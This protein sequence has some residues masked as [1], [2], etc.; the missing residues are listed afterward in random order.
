MKQRGL[1]LIELMMALAMGS[2]LIAGAVT[3]YVRSSA[4]YAVNETVARL[5]ETAR[6]AVS[7]LEPHIRLAGHWGLGGGAVHMKGTTGNAPLALS[8]AASRCGTE[9][10]LDLRRAAG[11]YNNGY[12][13]PC[14]AAGGGAVTGSDVLV[15]R[16]GEPVTAPPSSERLQLYTTRSGTGNR[17]FLSATAPGVTTDAE[18][19]DLSAHAYYLARNS[20]GQAG[21]PALRRKVLQ[22]GPGIGDEEIMPG[23]EDFQVRFGIDPGVDDD[24]DGNPDHHT[25]I[26]ARYVDPGDTALDSALIVA[27]RIWLRVRSE[28]P[29]RGHVD[30]RTYRYADVTFHPVGDDAGYRRLLV[31][32]TIQLRNAAGIP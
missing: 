26:A 10:P 5:H 18:I 21:L 22:G 7:T 9:F 20:T 28:Q 31:S 32:R 1:S 12:G 15:V 13:L 19:H 24:G 11:G 4:T 2:F 23:V 16:H 30:N 17:L 29:D 25:G 3:V 14:A 6:F 8:A 27:V